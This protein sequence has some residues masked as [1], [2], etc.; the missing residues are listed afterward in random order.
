MGE[1]HL[2]ERRQVDAGPRADAVSGGFGLGA[3]GVQRAAGGG[4]HRERFLLPA[5]L[6][7]CLG[8]QRERR[9]PG[10]LRIGLQRA[11]R[12]DELVHHH[13]VAHAIGM[14]RAG[15]IGKHLRRGRR[16]RA[17]Q[18]RQFGNRQRVDVD[19]QRQFQRLR[20]LCRPGVRRG[21]G[22]RQAH[23]DLAQAQPFHMQPRR[24]PRR[25]PSAVDPVDADA[26]VAAGVDHVTQPQAAG[27]RTALEG[28][29][30]QAGREAR[31]QRPELARA[32]LGAQRHHGG[33]DGGDQQRQQ[34]GQR[35]ANHPPDAT[36]WSRGA[37]RARF[38]LVAAGHGWH[39]HMHQNAT[40][41]E[42]CG[43]NW[44]CWMP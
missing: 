3:Q 40:P 20:H 28:A 25:A 22:R 29:G 11:V 21:R 5:A 26:R 37:R 31:G 10:N 36:Y 16:G 14:E 8:G 42:I 17:L 15:K 19:G 38:V 30:Q 2:A 35:P 39:V 6:Q 7:Q 18:Q 27:D 44:F 24:G 13:A 12:R 33:G 9:L 1:R 23:V 32:G 43:R 41:S 4:R 34:H